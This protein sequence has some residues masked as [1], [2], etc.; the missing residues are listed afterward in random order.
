MASLQL[1]NFN[2]NAPLLKSKFENE[3]FSTINHDEIK[4]YL[5]YLIENALL[6]T[7]IDPN[8]L[9]FYATCNDKFNDLEYYKS[10]GECDFDEDNYSDQI[11][12]R[13][14]KFSSAN[15][16]TLHL[17]FPIKKLIEFKYAFQNNDKFLFSNYLFSPK[18]TDLTVINTSGYNQD[19]RSHRGDRSLAES[20]LDIKN[21]HTIAKYDN[22]SDLY[23][24][25]NEQEDSDYDSDSYQDNFDSSNIQYN[26]ID[27]Y[28][29]SKY[30]GEYSISNNDG[31]TYKDLIVATMISKSSKF[32]AWYELFSKINDIQFV[33]NGNKYH[34]TL[35]LDFDHGS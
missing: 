6:N 19:H 2:I 4:Y 28:Y 25:I 14:I 3:L 24:F 33:K 20:G 12:K 1:F 17:N 15:L 7:Y 22:I 30:S 27:K 21:L 18:I 5:H 16:S 32:D 10:F 31:I 11:Y 35:Y 9:S 26:Y 29:W 8:T 23:N 34:L 13:L